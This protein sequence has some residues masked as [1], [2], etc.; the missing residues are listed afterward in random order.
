MDNDGTIEME[1]DI[2]KFCVLYVTGEVTK[3]GFEPVVGEWNQHR[4]PAI[5][6]FF[7]T[8]FKEL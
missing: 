6:L 8:V 1:N 5:F 7:L 2:L 3:V 4:I